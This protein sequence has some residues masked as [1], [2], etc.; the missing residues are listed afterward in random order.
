MPLAMMKMT[1]VMMD[2]M[3]DTYAML[4]RRMEL[5]RGLDPEDVAKI[6]ARGITV[7]YEAEQVIFEKGQAGKD[8]Y[9]ILG[10]EVQIYDEGREIARLDPLLMAVGQ[11]DVSR[12]RAVNTVERNVREAVED[13]PVTFP[14]L[15]FK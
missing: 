15:K 5:F 12:F 9:V 10:G 3:R 13:D 14:R 7:E 8:L 1:T 11:S 6:F 2:S 4:A